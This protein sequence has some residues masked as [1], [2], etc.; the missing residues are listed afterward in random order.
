MPVYARRLEALRQT[1]PD[2]ARRVTPY[3]EHLQDWNFESSLTSTQATLAVEWYEQLYG[4]GYPVETLEPRYTSD[5]PARF[6]AL[7]RAAERLVELYGS[8]KVPYGDV[9][10]IQRHAPYASSGEVP[11]SDELPSLPLAGVRGPLGVAFT[12][13]HSPPATLED[14]TE[15]KL[16]YAATGASYM[17]VYEFGSR[18][19]RSA[20]TRG[21][22]YLHYGQSHRPDSPHFFDQ[23]KPP[24]GA[25][26]QAGVALL[27]RR[28]EATPR[29]RTA[30][31]RRGP[32]V[33]RVQA[34][35]GSRRLCGSRSRDLRRPGAARRVETTGA[36][37]E[38]HGGDGEPTGVGGRRPDPEARR[39][40]RRRG[41]RRGLRAG[42]DLPRPPATSVAAAS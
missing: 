23:A 4:R 34:V 40:C 2:L 28:R 8:W 42:R 33:G 13:Y 18:S 25:T 29:G 22:S 32:D 7:E 21:A 10:R 9:H 37:R 36:G 6:E 11:F 5:I 14:G 30:P 26:L 19:K 17:A 16:R 24:V 35:V 15:R 41:G 39:Q 12:L 1:H 20:R 27:G 31:A 38:R 3:M